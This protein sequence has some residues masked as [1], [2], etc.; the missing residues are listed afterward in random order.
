MRLRLVVFVPFP[1]HFLF[2]HKPGGRHTNYHL[3]SILSP[4]GRLLS[5]SPKGLAHPLPVVI[6]GDNH[7]FL[8][9]LKLKSP[10]G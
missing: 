6:T 4:T 8:N 9:Q 3:K 5:L 1:N 7:R 10:K 2:I